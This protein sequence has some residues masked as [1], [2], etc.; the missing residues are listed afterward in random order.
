MWNNRKNLKKCPVD[1]FLKDN[2]KLRVKADPLQNSCLRNSQL[3]VYILLSQI[4]ACQL[5]A[6][7]NH[8]PQPAVS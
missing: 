6:A 4:Q 3:S 5:R 7:S 2:S 1:Y 8:F